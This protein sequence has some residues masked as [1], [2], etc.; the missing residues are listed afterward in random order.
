[1]KSVSVLS[2]RNGR[3]DLVASVMV[4]VSVGVVV[5]L[6]CGVPPSA[7]TCSRPLAF[8]VVASVSVSNDGSRSS[9]DVVGESIL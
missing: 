3:A 2:P 8:G 4:D 1:M 7:E 6:P 5:P 9:S